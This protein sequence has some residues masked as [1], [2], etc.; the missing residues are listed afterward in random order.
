MVVEVAATQIWPCFIERIEAEESVR[1]YPLTWLHWEQDKPNVYGQRLLYISFLR[2]LLDWN[3]NRS[4]FVRVVEL[5]RSLFIWFIYVFCLFIFLHLSVFC[6]F[7]PSY[8]FF[9]PLWTQCTT[10]CGPGYQMRAVK[11]VVGSYGA[12]MDDTEC[13]AATRPTDTQVWRTLSFIPTSL[14][15]P[16]NI[17]LLL[18]S[19]YSPFMPSLLW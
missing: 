18:S 19:S 16:I 5:S 2:L 6:C 14:I 9:S 12:V 4:A 17:F 3:F 7:I 15:F 13:N 10:S 11:C 8:A 1:S